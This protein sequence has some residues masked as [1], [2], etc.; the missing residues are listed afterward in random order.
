MEKRKKIRPGTPMEFLDACRSSTAN[1]SNLHELLAKSASKKRT[2][3]RI[4]RPSS[5]LSAS[6][7]STIEVTCASKAQDFQP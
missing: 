6:P 2:K 4:I 1:N 3:N 5:V 7:G